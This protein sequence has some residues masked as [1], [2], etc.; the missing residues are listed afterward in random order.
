MD[1]VSHP[2]RLQVMA[3]ALAGI[4][5][6]MGARLIRGSY[7]ANIKERRDCSTALFDAQGACI[8]QAAHI[9]VHLG[10]LAEAVR[11]VVAAGP[12][13]GDVFVLNDPYQGGSHLPDITVVTAI[14]GLRDPE[15]VCAYAVNRAH[16]ADIGGMRPGSMPA[17]STEIWQEGLVIPP[18]RLAQMTL[19]GELCWQGDLLRLILA[20][21]RNPEQRQGD[22]QAQVG[23]SA[24]GV[25]RFRELLA[26]FGEEEAWQLIAGVIAYSRRRMQ[27]QIQALPAGIY[28]ACDYLEGYGDPPEPL[29]IQVQIEVRGE[30]LRVD[31]AGTAPA[32]AGNLNAPLAV[33]R[34]AVLFALRCLLDPTAPSNVGLEDPIEIVAPPGCLVNA[35]FPAA[36]VA[37][38]VETSQRIA[39]V[40]FKA[41]APVA[42]SRAIAQGQGTMNNCVLGNRHFTYYETLGGG[43]GA[44]R[45]RPG[46]DGVHVGM[47]NTLN[48]PIEALELEYPLRVLRYELRPDSGGHGRQRGGW[49]LI[50]S[51]QTLQDC[52]LSLLTDRRH[53]APQGEEGGEPGQVGIN[54]VNG[55]PLPSKIS[56]P[57]KAG[58]VLTLYTPGGGAWGAREEEGPGG[59][60]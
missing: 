55:D 8:A 17:D 43:Q 54:L 18:L 53:H 48:T 11:A 60:K 41:L 52:T 20:N 15:Q 24:V 34:S 28:T 6:E 50:R 9:P 29:R 1:S 32:T 2:I 30:R 35:Q 5:E 57:L 22:L 44:S 37:G 59:P 33:T 42:G 4:A 38:N 39:D 21:V 12:R 27:A 51:L 45:Q 49:G 23:A 25:S 16:H 56:R 26:R 13:P 7:S 10:A 58:D 14:P 36:V 47:S 31:F 40:V 3:N 19:T 46:L